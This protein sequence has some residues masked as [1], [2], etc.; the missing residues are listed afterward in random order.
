MS[1]YR[2]LVWGTG[3]WCEWLLKELPENCV[4]EAFIETSPLK[5]EFKMK[6][7]ISPKEFPQYYIDT[8]LTIVAVEKSD[9]ITKVIK[10]SIGTLKNIY[11]C[12]QEYGKLFCNSIEPVGVYEIK[13]IFLRY[14]IYD[15]QGVS[16][17]VN[18]RFKI[19][20]NALAGGDN[21]QQDDIALFMQL[22]R[23]YYKTEIEVRGDCP[24]TQNP[25]LKVENKTNDMG[26]Y[27]SKVGSVR[28][29]DGSLKQKVETVNRDKI[30]FGQPEGGGYF[31][32]VGGNIGTTS[33][34]V[35]KKLKPQLKI[36]AF[37]PVKE[38]C[39][40][41]HCNC[42]LNNITEDDYIL[43]EAALSNTNSEADCMISKSNLGD[44][45]VIINGNDDKTRKIEKV[46][47]L[48]LDD[49]IEKNG[50]ESSKIRYIWM[51][52]QAHEGFVIDGAL[53][54]LTD[55]DI[56]LFME[57]W[58]R[59]LKKNQ[60]LQLLVD[61]L[62]KCNYKKFVVIQW[63]EQGNKREFDIYKLYEIAE[64]YPDKFFDIFLVK[65]I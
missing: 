23:K 57:F 36:I 37:E 42:I 6:K 9:E 45:R 40:Q 14:V 44:N 43:V 46:K 26:L 17:L 13:R 47:T 5:S 12:R 30:V 39:K 54:T 2:I 8:D 35:K 51:D 61:G 29:C 64:E 65:E 38:N 49:W 15:C 60:S 4:I 53:R 18:N 59:E 16:F 3:N 28:D 1:Q 33:I 21:F 19:M 50:I 41:F 11:F 63:Y 55:N 7:V 10:T 27:E 56:P 34:W 32:D 20:T 48:R 22:A 24:K 31:L 58:P 62:I 52:V 25:N